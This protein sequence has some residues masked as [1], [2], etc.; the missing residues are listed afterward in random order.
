MCADCRTNANTFSIVCGKADGGDWRGNV[1]TATHNPPMFNGFKLKSYFGG[2]AESSTCQEI[3]GYLDRNRVKATA[4]VGK[5]T[6]VIIK[7]IRP[8]HYAALK[9]S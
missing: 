3:E 4:G 8:A 7:D 6:R 1:I 5:G 9:N 2:S